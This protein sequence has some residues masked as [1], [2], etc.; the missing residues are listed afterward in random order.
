MRHPT[1]FVAPNASLSYVAGALSATILP[2]LSKAPS[3]LRLASPN[4]LEALL[5]VDIH[6]VYVKRLIVNKLTKRNRRVSLG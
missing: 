1:C 3:F 2:L 4:I 5:A 6:R